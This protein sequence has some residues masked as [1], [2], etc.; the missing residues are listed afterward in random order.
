[1][2]DLNSPCFE[3]RDLLTDRTCLY[4]EGGEAVSWTRERRRSSHEHVTRRTVCVGECRIQIN[5]PEPYMNCGKSEGRALLT[6]RQKILRIFV[7]S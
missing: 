7:L 4:T 3:A 2:R 5:V 1:M 6:E